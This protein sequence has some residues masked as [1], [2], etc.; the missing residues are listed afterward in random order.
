MAVEV[1]RIDVGFSG[2]QVLALRATKEAYDGL[3][4]ALDSDGGNRWHTL[5]TEDSEVLIDLP[6]VVYVRR[7]TEEHKVGF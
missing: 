5:E 6:Q 7:D 1:K 2:G 4:G 3:V